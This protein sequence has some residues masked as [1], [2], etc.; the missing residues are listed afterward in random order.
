MSDHS[1]AMCLTA[2]GKLRNTRVQLGLSLRQV[3]TRTQ[4]VAQQR[5]NEEFAVSVS[6]LSEIESKDA[7][8]NIYKL[9]SL[10]IVYGIDLLTLL[11]WYGVE[12][13]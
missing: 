4:A 9:Y 10:A 8:P 3:N 13:K 11:R 1:V 12:Y 2:G 7:V 6:R 5:G